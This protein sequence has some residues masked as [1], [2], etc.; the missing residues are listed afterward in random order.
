LGVVLD[1]PPR[2][3]TPPDT[4][5]EAL[6]D[7]NEIARRVQDLDAASQKA[8][9]LQAAAD[10]ASTPGGDEA[11]RVIAGVYAKRLIEAN[12][13]AAPKIPPLTQPQAPDADNPDRCATLGCPYPALPGDRW[14]V[15][16][17][18]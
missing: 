13:T 1:N 7:V 16:C 14:C 11:L 2:P 10:L 5:D 4:T 12:K 3:V 6:A 18:R 15:R 17:A 9:G 8:L